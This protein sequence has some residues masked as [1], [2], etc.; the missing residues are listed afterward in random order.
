MGVAMSWHGN[1]PEHPVD[2]VRW[3]AAP[4]AIQGGH[5]DKTGGIFGE[6]AN[7]PVLRCSKRSCLSTGLGI[8]H[9]LG[10]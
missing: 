5:I 8:V 2:G 1:K 3:A 6:V 7:T 4:V 9:L 10:A